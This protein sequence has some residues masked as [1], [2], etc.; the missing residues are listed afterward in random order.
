MRAPGSKL[1]VAVV[2][3]V[4]PD[5]RSDRIPAG[6]PVLLR[7]RATW[8]PQLRSWTILLGEVAG[9]ANDSQPSDQRARVAAPPLGLSLSIPSGRMPRFKTQLS[10]KPKC[11]N[12]KTV[13]HNGQ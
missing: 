1:A 7:V 13:P 6:S 2:D 3:V 5:R 10:K 4:S 12:N 8:G 11:L 9:N